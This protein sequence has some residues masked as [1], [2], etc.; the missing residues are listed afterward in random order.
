VIAAADTLKDTADVGEEG[1]MEESTQ[2]EIV[3]VWM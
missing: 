1:R 2:R 3:E